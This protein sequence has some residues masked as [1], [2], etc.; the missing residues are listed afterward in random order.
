M[1]SPQ[2]PHGGGDASADLAARFGSLGIG[3]EEQYP[4]SPGGAYATTTPRAQQSFNPYADPNQYGQY[5]AGANPYETP[6]TS[7]LVNQP[8]SNYPY[9]GPPPDLPQPMQAMG[10]YEAYG[11]AFQ[12][13]QSAAA[14]QADRQ[15]GATLQT[16]Y[17]TPVSNRSIASVRPSGYRPGLGSPQMADQNISARGQYQNW[18]DQQSGRGYNPGHQGERRRLSVSAD[19]R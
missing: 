9:G 8:S 19:A 5:Y 4:A 6:F 16:G 1:S 18:S 12:S 17:P 14:L 10:G 7:G 11:E 13:I 3:V 2:T 15:P